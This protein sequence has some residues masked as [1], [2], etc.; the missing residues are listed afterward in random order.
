VDIDFNANLRFWRYYDLYLIA[1]DSEQSVKSGTPSIPLNSLTSVQLGLRADVPLRWGLRTGGEVRF[2]ERD[3]EIAPFTRRDVHAYLESPLVFTTGK[4]RMFVRRAK[5]DI[6]S[7]PEDV[8]LTRYGLLVQSRP[9]LRTRIAVEISH[10][11]DTGGS[12]KRE[13]DLFS[14]IA[15]WQRRRLAFNLRANLRRE[16][17]GDL[18]RERVSVRAELVRKF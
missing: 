13:L 11:K 16:Q 7:S 3:E 15:S 18:D 2:E 14:L 6:D 9:F 10:E 1:R 17:Q 12:V 8:D 5:V 4:L